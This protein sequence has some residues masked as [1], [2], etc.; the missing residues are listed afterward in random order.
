MYFYI[1]VCYSLLYPSLGAQVQPTTHFV[2]LAVENINFCTAFT[3]LWCRHSLFLLF[4]LH[5]FILRLR[6]CSQGPPWQSTTKFQY[7]EVPKFDYKQQQRHLVFSFAF[8][9][10]PFKRSPF[11]LQTCL[12]SLCWAAV[13]CQLFFPHQK[14]EYSRRFRDLLS[15]HTWHYSSSLDSPAC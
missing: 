15:N 4:H 3:Q 11:L 14:H 12:V 1:S 9:A 13:R 2:L 10:I 5:S 8:S 7:L 6:G